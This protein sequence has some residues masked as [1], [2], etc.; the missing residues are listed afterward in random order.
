MRRR[1][2]TGSSLLAGMLLGIA[3]VS[4]CSPAPVADSPPAASTDADASA[5]VAEVAPTAAAAPSAS[6]AREAAPAPTPCGELDCMQY[7][8]AKEA[9]RAVLASSPA[10]VAVG[11][12]HAQKGTEHIPTAT[13]RFTQELL[14]LLSASKSDLVLELMVPDPKCKKATKKVER[15][16]EK[17]V[18]NTQRESNKTEFQVMAEAAKAIGIRP[19]VLRPSC[20]QMKKVADAGDNGVL[21]ML[22]LI[23]YLSDDISRRI[24]QRN[25]KQSVQKGVVLYGGAMHNDMAPREGRESFSF[26]PALAQHVEGS[27]V[28]IDLIVPEYIK[29][30]DTWKSLPWHAHYDVKKLGARVTLFKTGPKS[31]TLIFPAHE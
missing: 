23:A 27:Y 8:T 15:N 12:A 28:E 9:F 6:Q 11:E 16:V 21:K 4:G 5:A 3:V 18:T 19:H 22:S 29:D 26:G 30:S 13:K 20:A 2:V 17:P 14:P 24:L 25:E 7:A 31:Y 10:V 1:T